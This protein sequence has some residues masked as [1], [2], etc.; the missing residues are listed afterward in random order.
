MNDSIRVR[1]RPWRAGPRA[2]RTAA[3]VIATAA[4]AMLVAACRGSA[5]SAGSGGSS[6]A[7]GSSSSSSAVG[8]SHCMR[9]RG[10]P[11][12]PDPDS[13]GQLPKGDAQR[14]GVSG[15]QLQAARQACQPLLPNSGEAINADS[16]QQCMMAGD[17]PQALVQH[18]LSEERNFARCMHSHGVPNWPDPTIDSQGRPVF[19]ISI[20]KDGFDPYSSQIWAKG[21]RCSRLMPGLPGLPAAVSP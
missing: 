9:S 10:V 4:L 11:N 15:S 3:A 14:F 13:S 19:A 7:G 6:N 18:V 2:A 8:Y 17:C 12:F 21:N 16:I 1:R 5:A 20:S